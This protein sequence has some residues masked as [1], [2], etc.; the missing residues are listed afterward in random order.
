MHT[1]NEKQNKATAR[2]LSYVS[3][4]NEVTLGEVI[5]SR[6]GAGAYRCLHLWVDSRW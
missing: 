3:G 5:P 6:V 2:T 4:E 1:P